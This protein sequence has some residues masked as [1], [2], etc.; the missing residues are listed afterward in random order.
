M[1]TNA[2]LVKSV[3]LPSMEIQFCHKISFYQLNLS[4]SQER[5]IPRTSFSN[6]NLNKGHSSY[7]LSRND[8]ARQVAGRLQSITPSLVS[9]PGRAKANT[10]KLGDGTASIKLNRYLPNLTF[11]FDL[12]VEYL[13]YQCRV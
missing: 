1:A 5:H 3:N 7:N 11:K 10:I 8:V 9:C 6:G 4:S 2:N 13:P 12:Y